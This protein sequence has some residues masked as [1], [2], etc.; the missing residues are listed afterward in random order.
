[1]AYS[2]KG[3]LQP[4]PVTKSFVAAVQQCCLQRSQREISHL[5]TF[6]ISYIFKKNQ[7]SSEVTKTLPKISYQHTLNGHSTKPQNPKTPKL[8]P[9]ASYSMRYGSLRQPWPDATA[10][11]SHRD[12]VEAPRN[13]RRFSGKTWGFPWRCVFRFFVCQLLCSWKIVER[14]R[15]FH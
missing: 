15:R 7:I 2:C 4:S 3:L 12:L 14:K 6:Q 11:P 10:L 9:D 5:N 8:P 1:M 13:L